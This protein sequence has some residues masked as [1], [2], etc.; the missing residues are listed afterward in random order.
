[1]FPDVQA[2][3][4]NIVL[5]VE[6]KKS[7][8]CVFI[9]FLRHLSLNVFFNMFVYHKLLI[10]YLLFIHKFPNTS[11]FSYS[12]YFLYITEAFPYFKTVK[13]SSFLHI[14]KLHKFYISFQ[15][16][17]YAPSVIILISCQSINISWNK[18]NNKAISVSIVV[19]WQCS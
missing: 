8:H 5:E 19:N 13:H 3:L 15:N 16:F 14:F 1:M 11:L 18:M 2:L 12:E 10:L 4:H 9:A 7:H 17:Q 6:V